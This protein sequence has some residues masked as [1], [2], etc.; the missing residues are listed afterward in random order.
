[1]ANPAGCCESIRA[2]V[3]GAAATN[4][5]NCFFSGCVQQRLPCQQQ[6]NCT[7]AKYRDKEVPVE[8]AKVTS[9]D[10]S[11]SP[12]DLYDV[13][14]YGYV[15]KNHLGE[16]LSHIWEVSPGFLNGHIQVCDLSGLYSAHTIHPDSKPFRD[17][18]TNSCTFLCWRRHAAVP[19]LLMDMLE[20]TV[21]D[22]LLADTR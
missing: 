14:P 5:K 8:T 17:T 19:V 10:R 9:A 7:K 1:M 4:M 12:R 15:W 22:S 2:H 13:L 20:P 3:D 16:P 18:Q 11:T 21:R 6:R